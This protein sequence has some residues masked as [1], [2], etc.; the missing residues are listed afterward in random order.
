MMMYYCCIEDIFEGIFD[1]REKCIK[2]IKERF[3]A[4]DWMGEKPTL[5]RVEENPYEYDR[6][7]SPI[8]DVLYVKWEGIDGLADYEII[9]CNVNTTYSC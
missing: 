7:S 9:G 1:S 2:A 3:N 8:V 6:I 5:E 4:V